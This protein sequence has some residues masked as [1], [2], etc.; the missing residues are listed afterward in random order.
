[1]NTD[2]KPDSG[3]RAF[4]LI[5]LLVVIAIIAILAAFLL[6]ALSRAKS[7]AHG[8]YC[9]NNTKQLM[10][11]MTIYSQDYNDFFPPNYDDGNTTPYY[12]WVGGQA[13][14]GGGNE[15][16][17]DILKDPTRSLLAPYQGKNVSIYHCPAD[18]RKPGTANGM[19]AAN[20]ALKGVQISNSR[21]VAMNQ[22]VGTDPYKGGKAAVSG[23]WLTGSHDYSQR[24]WYTYGKTTS[25]VKP[26]PATTFTILD[27]DKNSINDGG[28]AT[29]GPKDPPLY[30]MIDWPSTGHGQA[31]GFAF[32]DNHSEIHRWKDKRTVLL[33]PGY[34]ATQTGNLDVW[35]MAVKA[36]ALINGPTFG[37]R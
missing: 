25:M 32:G 18:V 13:G 30:Q 33:G 26:G 29:V 28:F 23:P 11:A 17:P 19:S 14:V 1:M 22:A 24:Q 5:E 15:F 6:P 2:R 4:T 34:T 9:M 20:P 21:S 36:S 27:E 37:V 10:L 3:R 31:C 16:D 8:I 12:N 35:W 7:K